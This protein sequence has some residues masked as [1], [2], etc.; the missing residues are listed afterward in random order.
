MY[1]RT[2]I[3]P[4]VLLWKHVMFSGGLVD[5]KDVFSEDR[6][7]PS[8]P[9]QLI[10]QGV[11]EAEW[12]RLELKSSKTRKEATRS[13]PATNTEL[14]PV[15][16][17]K[18]LYMFI[19]NRDG[20]PPHREEAVLWSDTTGRVLS[21]AEINEVLKFAFSALELE[22]SDVASHSL[23]RGGLS[24]YLATKCDR[25][26]LQVFGFWS[27]LRGMLSY[28]W[29]DGAALLNTIFHAQCGMPMLERTYCY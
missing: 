21:A 12:L 15:K 7:S 29:I 18:E 20:R 19:L 23:R 4:G 17:M 5:L 26:L 27:S 9:M 22:V 2:R 25:N 10:G 6:D 28:E 14:C 13:L 3:Y 16:A 11:E 24:A 1:L 8:I